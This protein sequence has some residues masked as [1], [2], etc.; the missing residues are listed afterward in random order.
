MLDQSV[1]AL[2]RRQMVAREIER[3]ML[4][5]TR[6]H[7][8]GLKTLVATAALIIAYVLGIAALFNTFEQGQPR[9]NL[10]MTLIQPSAQSR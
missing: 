5:T 9:L 6:T 1:A 7:H 2:A 4:L 10:Q 3:S 8:A